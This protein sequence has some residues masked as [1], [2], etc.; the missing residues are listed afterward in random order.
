MGFLLQQ[1]TYEDAIESFG[2]NYLEVEWEDSLVFNIPED[3][4]ASVLR[5]IEAVRREGGSVLVHCA[6][7]CE[8]FFFFKICFLGGNNFF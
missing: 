1:T 8:A 3:D 6:Q 4:L 7:V 5:H 2:I